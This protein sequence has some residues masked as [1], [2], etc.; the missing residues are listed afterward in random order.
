MLVV[1]VVAAAIVYNI[2]F[3]DINEQLRDGGGAPARSADD[4]HDDGRSQ[5]QNDDGDIRAEPPLRPPCKTGAVGQPNRVVAVVVGT[6][7]VVVADDDGDDDIDY[8]AARRS[9]EVVVDYAED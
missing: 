1:V 7:G 2:T 4:E 8:S 9:V 6:I 3:R 5:V